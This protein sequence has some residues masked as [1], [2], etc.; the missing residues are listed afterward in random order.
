MSTLRPDA[1]WLARLRERLDRP[2]LKP[3][4]P[5]YWR[6][7]AIGSVEPE[8]PAAVGLPR[9]WQRDGDGW[10][11]LGDTLTA[12]LETIGL[13]IESAGLAHVRRNE[14]LAVCGPQGEVLGTVERGVIRTLGIPTRAV[15]LLGFVPDGRQWVQQR[16]FSK[17]NDPGLWDTLVGGMVPACDSLEEALQRE[18]WEEAGLRLAALRDVRPG[19]Q[20]LTRRPTVE[21]GPGYV[22][23]RID[24]YRCVVPEGMVP[25][26]QDG[27][28][29]AFALLAMGEVARRLERDEFTP[30]AAMLVVACCA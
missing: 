5:L 29:A 12:S 26:N 3:R 30:E 2:P 1:A 9:L 14:Q 18:T 25:D 13:A 11:V 4:E 10:S 21:P 28:V 6:G 7:Q 23:E 8:V 16:S 24:W 15:H 19:G 27:E 20:I 22:V 17:A